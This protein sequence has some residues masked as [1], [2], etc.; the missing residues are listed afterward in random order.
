MIDLGNAYFVKGEDD[1]AR[2]YFTQALEYA[3]RYKS[4]RNQARALLSLGSLRLQRGE[5]GE[6]LRNVEEALA[7]YQR[8]GYQKETAQALILMGRAQRERGDYQA[9]L[10]AVKYQ[11][12]SENP[13]GVT[14]TVTFKVPSRV[15]ARCSR[16]RSAGPTHCSATRKH[17]PPPNSP[18]TS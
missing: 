17:T 10:R 9:A 1:E 6:G 14:R 11:N 13:N 8:G 2:K 7:W 16:R 12:T 5:T 3:R 15:S 18:A 4:P